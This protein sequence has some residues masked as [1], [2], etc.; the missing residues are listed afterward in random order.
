M[1][2]TQGD[3]Y[4]RKDIL[5]VLANNNLQSTGAQYF[6]FAIFSVSVLLIF[7]FPQYLLFIIFNR[8]L[9]TSSL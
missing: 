4:S 3:N 6:S 7:F 5:R 1:G 8:V 2:T 9:V